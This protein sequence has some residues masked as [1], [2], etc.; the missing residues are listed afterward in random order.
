MR[1]AA[2]ARKEWKLKKFNSSCEPTVRRGAFI[3]LFNYP[4]L[5]ESE[6]LAKFRKITQLRSRA[7]P[8][9]QSCTLCLFTLP[10]SA[11]LVSLITQGRGS[12]C[13]KPLAPLVALIPLRANNLGLSGLRV[14]LGRRRIRVVSHPIP[15]PPALE[16]DSI[17]H[18][19][20]PHPN[21]SFLTASSHH[22]A[23][24][25]SSCPSKQ[26]VSLSL[27]RFLMSTLN[28]LI[29]SFHLLVALWQKSPLLQ[30]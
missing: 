17:S 29:F 23:T 5:Q 15:H 4:K 30:F 26:S 18:D 14:F 24:I 7:L 21:F 20:K 22:D 1:A 19:G 10:F 6:R 11:S 8:R 16:A 25:S 2:R 28:D 9:F 12:L 13:P 3:F 27:E